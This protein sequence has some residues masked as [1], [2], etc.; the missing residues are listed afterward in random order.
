MNLLLSL[1]SVAVLAKTGLGADS[2]DWNA[3]QWEAPT[4]TDSRGPCPGLNTLANHGFLPRNGSNITIPTVLNAINEGF[5]FEIGYIMRIAAKV[6]L[7]A[8]E[9]VDNF[10]LLDLALHGTLE[11][12]A[13]ISRNDFAL[14][15]NVHFNETVFTTLAEANPGADFY[16]I[17]SAAQVLEQRLAIDKV[18]N[19]N[20]IN[21]EKE[22]FVR[23]FESA[24]Y[25]SAMGNVTTGVAPKNFVQILFREERLPLEE[26]WRR[27]EVPITED[28]LE[29]LGNAIRI[30]TTWAPSGAVICPWIRVEPEGTATIVQG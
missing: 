21:T 11:H 5:N 4:A 1:L 19:P 29:S 3:H 28:S 27:P 24:F 20:L 14:G 7:L 9:N 22:F 10:S 23:Y 12:D 30:A 15:D 17:T 6:G 25:L 16:N 2:I 26:G 8:T 18:V 13:S